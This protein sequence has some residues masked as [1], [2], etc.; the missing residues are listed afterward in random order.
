MIKWRNLLDVFL[1]GLCFAPSFLFFKVAAGD[2]NPL[3]VVAVRLGLGG[4]LLYL[5]CRFKG[6]KL[7][8]QPK[9]WG[10]L[11]I[12]GFLSCSL[13]FT[14]FAITELKLSSAMAGVISGGT[15]IFTALAGHF[16]LSE[17]RLTLGRLMGVG[18]GLMGFCLLILP[19]VLA[20]SE[21]V[22][23]PFMLLLLIAPISY[24]ASAIYTRKVGLKLSPIVSAAGMLLISTAYLIPLAL[25]LEVATGLSTLTLTNVG[26]MMGLGVIGSAF[27][28]VLLFRIIEHSGAVTLSMAAYVMTGM[29]T[30]L[31]FVV[32]GEA[33]HWTAYLALGLIVLGVMVVNGT[34]RWPLRNP[35]VV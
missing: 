6:L 18:L 8:T 5:Y 3:T 35:Q 31:G 34:V 10:Q 25:V 15:P 2:V 28:Y 1:L 20:D 32:L 12:M 21:E 7:P 11:A 16:L 33:L 17:E 26:A 30:V 13:P 22:Y 29:A 14:L 24:A 9:V 23:V 19:N 4:F 27:A